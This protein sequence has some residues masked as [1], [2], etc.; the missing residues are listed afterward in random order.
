MEPR[1]TGG[2]FMRGTLEKRLPVVLASALLVAI[3]FGPVEAG[4]IVASGPATSIARPGQHGLLQLAAGGNPAVC[5]ANY[6]QCVN[7][8]GGMSGCANQCATNYRKCL[9]Q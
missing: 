8:C 9:G 3:G 2:W 7:A 5:K 4:T 1:Q 6:E